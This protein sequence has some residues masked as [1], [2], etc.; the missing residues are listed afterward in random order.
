M[1][2]SE[3]I[4]ESENVFVIQFMEERV[5]KMA[6]EKKFFGVMTTNTN[7]LTQQIAIDIHG[8]EVLSEYQVNHFIAPDETKPFM[9]APD[10]FKIVCCWKRVGYHKLNAEATFF[11]ENVEVSEET[12]AVEFD[13]VANEEF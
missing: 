9:L 8:Y 10:S 5:I 6:E 7:A 12:S 4:D 11:R 2:T 1:G 3:D 13:S